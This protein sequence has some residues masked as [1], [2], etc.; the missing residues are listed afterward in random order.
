MTD[1]IIVYTTTS[2]KKEAETIAKTLVS[3]RLVA[4]VN[5][6]PIKSTYAWNGRLVHEKEYILLSKTVKKKLPKIIKK[7]REL[8]SYALPAIIAIPI[9]DGSKGYL[10][11][12][13]NA[14]V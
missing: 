3:E 14:V 13:Q 11:W 2:G 8:H 9:V 1:F 4:C 7:I 5:Y 6:F 10:D 12:I